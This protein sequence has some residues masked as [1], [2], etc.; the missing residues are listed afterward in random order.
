MIEHLREAKAVELEL[1]NQLQFF[2]ASVWLGNPAGFPYAHELNVEDVQKVFRKHHIAGSLISHW[3]SV[4]VSA[5]NGNDALCHVAGRL[6]END[7]LIYTGLPLY[8]DGESVLSDLNTHSNKIRGLRLFPESHNFPLTGWVLDSL[9]QWLIER[10]VP[11]FMW[12]V[13]IELPDLYGLAKEYPQLTIVLESQTKKIL[14]QS[15]PLFSLMRDCPNVML[16]ISNYV[17][18]GFI[19]YAVGHFSAERLIY[20]SFLPACD[21]FVPM[22]MVLNADISRSEKALI[23][24]GNIRRIIEGVHLR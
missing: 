19:E 18:P 21:P 17:G 4:T 10:N 12:H 3:M 23:A 16:E 24:G 11:L 8:P 15:R 9:C 6:T 2:D 7:Y 22:G 5:Q 14:Y 20:G 1:A 13:E